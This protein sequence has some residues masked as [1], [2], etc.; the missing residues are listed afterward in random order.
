MKMKVDDIAVVTEIGGHGFHK[1]ERIKIVSVYDNDYNAKIFKNP[2]GVDETYF[3]TSIDREF[4]S[5]W[6]NDS[7]CKLVKLA[8]WEDIVDMVHTSLDEE[9]KSSLI[10]ALDEKYN[11]PEEK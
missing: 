9:L 5:W 3:A 7:K 8:S 1:G 4:T 10:K 2:A 11:L 6:L